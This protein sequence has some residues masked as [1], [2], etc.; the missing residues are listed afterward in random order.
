MSYKTINIIM[1]PDSELTS[2]CDEMCKAAKLFKNAVIFR[3]RQLLTAKYKDY[4]DL[5]A[6][7]Q[8]VLDEFKLTEDRFKPITKKYYLPNYNHFDY[9]FKKTNNPD[10]YNS[11]PMQSTQQIIKEVLSNFKGY[12][13]SCKSY[14]KNPSLFTGKP[15]IPGYV[16]SDQVSFDITNQGCVVKSD[17]FYNY[18]KLPKTKLTVDLGNL[19]INKLKEVTIKPFYDTYKICIVSE[20]PELEVKSL[21][22]ENYLSLDLGIDNFIAT[23]NNCGLSPFIIKGNVIKSYNQWFNKKISKLQSLL[24]KNQYTSKQIQTLW[25]KRNNITTDFYNKTASYIVKYCI[26]NNIGN[27]VIGKNTYWK[28][29]SDLGK[30]NNQKFC[31]ISHAYFINKLMEMSKQVVINV[32]TNE[33]SYTSKASFLDKDIIPV[34]KDGQRPAFSGKRIHRGLYKSGTGILMNADVNGASNILKKAVETAFNKITN[35]EYLY[36]TVIN[37]S[38]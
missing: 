27:I 2:Y 15:K 9:M 1:K 5:Q 29:N 33:E 25:R 36:K 19:K 23:S 38:L 12:F 37:V 31:F 11:L 34:Y 32:I 16:K 14:K 21:N 20:E 13:Y 26:K 8:E 35:Y 6:N 3:C 28:Q 22:S 24:S 17:K 10:Y 4:F 18:L 7:E 30:I